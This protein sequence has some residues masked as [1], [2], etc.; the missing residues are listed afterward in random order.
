MLTE[1]ATRSKLPWRKVA[2]YITGVVLI[3]AAFAAMRGR[4][5][6]DAV[7]ATLR[8]AEWWQLAVLAL[9]PLLSWLLTSLMFLVFTR[10]YGPVG[11][12][13]MTALIG[14]S[15]LLNY[16]PMQPG[17]FGRA[18]Y[19]KTENGIAIGQSVK[20]ILL[21]VA[22]TIACAI[23][24]P[25][26]VLAAGQRGTG[27]T[28]LVILAPL[29]TMLLAGGALGLQS[30]RGFAWRLFIGAACRYADMAVAAVRYFVVFGMLE[31]SAGVDAARAAKIAAGAQVANLPP[32]PFGLREWAVEFLSIGNG[33]G[34]RV[35][36]LNRASEM[37][38]AIGVGMVSAVWLWRKIV[39]RR[40]SRALTGVISP[41]G[42]SDTA[43]EPPR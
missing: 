27:W 36:L 17:L 9:F 19:Q 34:L 8:A 24:M 32:I 4:G 18:A 35:D 39:R 12:V 11:L 40:H 38:V 33:S 15:W 22:T 30:P 1:P 42:S 37:L 14:A 5:G 28:I 13:E 31:P 26:C 29:V 7:V 20:V 10:R 23:L 3:A 41:V 16:L 21:S 2:G 25:L 43:C 6:I